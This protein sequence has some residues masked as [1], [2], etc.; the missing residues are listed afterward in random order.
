MTGQ[1]TADARH[2][3]AGRPRD[4]RKTPQIL[5]AVF[6]TIAEV[7][8]QSL[9]V[10]AVATRAGVSP[11]SVYR[12]WPTKQELVI[13]ALAASPDPFPLEGTGDAG[14]DFTTMLTDLAQ[15]L[16]EPDHMRLALL[17]ADP[18]EPE[19]S[20]AARQYNIPRVRRYLRS[21]LAER[22]GPDHPALDLLVDVGP[23]LVW[24]RT[25]VTGERI[26]APALAD[27][28]N[29][30]VIDGIAES[31]QPALASGTE[32]D[33]EQAPGTAGARKDA[34]RNRRKIIAAAAELM[35]ERPYNEVQLDDVASRAGVSRATLIRHVG[36]K[37]QLR[38][39]VYKQRF[40]DVIDLCDRS[41]AEPD[42]WRGIELL[43]RT[44]ATW[45]SKD[46][47]LYVY[48]RAADQM[49]DDEEWQVLSGRVFAALDEV[50]D[51]AKSAGALRAG[52]RSVDVYPLMSAA[53][54]AATIPGTNLSLYT[55][56]LLQGLR[57]PGT[58]PTVITDNGAR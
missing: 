58:G 22:V 51:R 21:L 46:A 28:L 19:V 16:S 15:R 26:D 56:I 30:Y 36:T 13:A 57:A 48:L 45:A 11:G 7:G 1:A 23:A 8:Y 4:E 42:P 35:A 44:A 43:F 12:R 40:R 17:A 31:R 32:V 53:T 54:T 6:A 38:I 37:H 24:Y 52:V 33:A 50:L 10:E 55:D 41:L 49:I 3:G 27:E 47:G 39:Q 18:N 14:V 29:R 2:S 20:N 25:L 5:R 9:R 34:V